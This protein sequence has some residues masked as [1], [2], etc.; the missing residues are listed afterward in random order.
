MVLNIPWV[1]PKLHCGPLA[2][3]SL[4]PSSSHWMPSV[5]RPRRLLVAQGSLSFAECSWVLVCITAMCGGH[6]WF[7]LSVLQEA[8][9]EVRKH[10]RWI[11]L[12]LQRVLDTRIRKLI[13]ELV[14]GSL[15]QHFLQVLGLEGCTRHWMPLLLLY[16]L[17]NKFLFRYCSLWVSSPS[18]ICCPLFWCIRKTQGLLTLQENQSGAL[19]MQA[20]VDIPVEGSW[21]SSAIQI[22]LPKGAAAAICSEHFSSL[23][24]FDNSTRSS[25]IILHS[26]RQIIPCRWGIGILGGNAHTWRALRSITIKELLCKLSLCLGAQTCFLSLHSWSL[27][28]I[29]E[30]P[31]VSTNMHFVPCVSLSQ[32]LRVALQELCQKEE[33]ACVNWLP[34]GVKLVT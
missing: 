2:Q 25:H 7:S 12:L 10:P 34:R 18:G 11:K 29:P 20:A 13:L 23:P 22:S 3:Q 6:R 28:I 16:R 26:G 5:W 14:Q 15:S 31:L 19:R 32:I 21:E 33:L 27:P 17:F 4:C 8:S 24:L 9:A 1:I 30:A